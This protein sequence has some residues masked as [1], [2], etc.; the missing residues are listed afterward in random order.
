MFLMC[1]IR[2]KVFIRFESNNKYMVKE[3][4]REKKKIGVY[5]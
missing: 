1:L 2:F 4:E 3:R 5:Y